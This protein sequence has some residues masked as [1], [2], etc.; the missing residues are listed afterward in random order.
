LG[1]KLEYRTCEMIRKKNSDAIPGHLYFQVP[2][3]WNRQYLF[4]RLQQEFSVL[5]AESGRRL[6]RYYDTFD[7]RMHQAGMILT[8][9][10][11]QVRAYRI[12]PPYSEIFCYTDP[13]LLKNYRRAC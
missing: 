8:W 5:K 12:D 13:D 6:I 7:G 1:K 3:G 10:S 9:D 4:Q 11:S 2:A